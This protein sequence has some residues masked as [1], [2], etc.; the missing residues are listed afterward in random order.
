MCWPSTDGFG[1]SLSLVCIHSAALLEKTNCS[2]VST[3]QL[4]IASML[5]MRCVSTSSLRTRTPCVLDLCRPCEC[6]RS[7][8]E[9]THA[10]VSLV[11]SIQLTP[12]VFWAQTFEQLCILGKQSLKANYIKF[13]DNRMS[14]DIESQPHYL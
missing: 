9:F 7:L 10:S 4:E 6:C 11:Y 3:Y 13:K 1:L 8:C 2:F 5:G 12:T 14:I